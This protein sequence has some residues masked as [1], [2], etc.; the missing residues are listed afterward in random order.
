MFDMRLLA[1]ALSMLLHPLWMTTGALVLCSR[2]DPFMF[3]DPGSQAG[4]IF[5]GLVFLMTALF[6]L[7]STLLMR[8]SGLVSDLTLPTRSERIPVYII[9][10]LYHGMCWYLVRRITDHPV[11][12]GI[13]IGAFITL[14]LV[15]LITLYWKIS[16]H[17]AGIGG[18]IGAVVAVMV[19]D[20]GEVTLALSGLFVLAGALGT[21]RLIVSDHTPAQVYTGTLL[22]FVCVF[23]S[24]ASGITT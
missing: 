8:R 18:L 1:N 21:A 12:L 3:L 5:L 11:T 9:G 2:I 24:A 17:M 15:L 14:L 22:G 6:P 7:V 16:A 10:L 23:A 13:V 19:L 4:L 20:G